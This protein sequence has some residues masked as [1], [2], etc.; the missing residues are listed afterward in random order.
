MLDLKRECWSLAR[1]ARITNKPFGCSFYCYLSP[2]VS[3]SFKCYQNL[4][5]S[6]SNIEFLVALYGIALCLLN[7]ELLVGQ[8]ADSSFGYAAVKEVDRKFFGRGLP[9]DVYL[10]RYIHR[11]NR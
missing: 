9:R 6:A 1:R 2:I 4:K 5:G 11:E 3:R 8:R 7:F 10:N